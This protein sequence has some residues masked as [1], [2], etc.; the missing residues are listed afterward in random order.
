MELGW[1]KICCW[2]GLILDKNIWAYGIRWHRY[3][4]SF[5]QGMMYF[6]N[7]EEVKEKFRI[8]NIEQYKRIIL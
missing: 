7:F 3:D 2:N 4:H 6:S 5:D 8:C 1:V